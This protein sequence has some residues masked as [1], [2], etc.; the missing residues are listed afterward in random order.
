MDLPPQ[1]PLR[2]R[3]ATPA[4][5]QR[6]Q[7]SHTTQSRG[8]GEDKTTGLSRGE[9]R[10]RLGQAPLGH[11]TRVMPR[12]A[13]LVRVALTCYRAARHHPVRIVRSVRSASAVLA[14]GLPLGHATRVTPRLAPLVRVVLPCCRAARHHP[15]A[16]S[17]PSDWLPCYR[18][19][20]PTPAALSH[21]QSYPDRSDR[22][23][24]SSHSRYAMY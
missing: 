18:T 24:S 1:L 23:I 22:E 19:V 9:R 15:S 20:S 8:V 10:T 12:L 14:W 17:T 2:R 11:A 4:K 7:S 3:E 16:S 5:S 21:R 6:T 13:P